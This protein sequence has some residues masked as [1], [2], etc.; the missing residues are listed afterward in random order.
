MTRANQRKQKNKVILIACE[1]FDELGFLKYLRRTRDRR[2]DFV[3]VQFENSEGRGNPK[4]VEVAIQV[5]AD[6]KYVFMDTDRY[7]SFPN[8][9]AIAE[10]LASSNNIEIIYSIPN[11]DHFILDALKVAPRGKNAKSQLYT[12]L[13]N[14]SPQKPDSYENILTI[15][16]LREFGRHNSSMSTLL[17]IFDLW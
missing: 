3:T 10:N 11:F 16:L 4:V 14:C 1:G 17:S 8:E 12:E 9:R 7:E 5:D 13:N 6:K 15:D 2:E